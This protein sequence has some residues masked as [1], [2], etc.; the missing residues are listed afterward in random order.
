MSARLE[1][2][3]AVQAGGTVSYQVGFTVTAAGDLSDFD[4]TA[5]ASFKSAVAARAQTAED[6]IT[7]TFSSASVLISES[8]T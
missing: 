7:L 5:R 1:R 3:E 4:A 2:I 6:A 8:P